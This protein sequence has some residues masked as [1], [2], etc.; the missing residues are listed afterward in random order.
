MLKLAPVP[1]DGIIA[2]YQNSFAYDGINRMASKVA[3]TRDP[4]ADDIAFFRASAATV[5]YYN[6]YSNGQGRAAL[7]VGP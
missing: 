7:I 1:A 3:G 2:D 5:Y 4:S 6:W